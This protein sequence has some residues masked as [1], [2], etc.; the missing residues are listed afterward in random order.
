M[1]GL[2]TKLRLGAVLLFSFVVLN[3]DGSQDPNANVGN[4]NLTLEDV[5]DAQGNAVDPSLFATIEE[6]NNDVDRATI[7]SDPSAEG[8]TGTFVGTATVT[9]TEDGQPDTVKTLRATG[10]ATLSADPSAGDT[11][12]MVVTIEDP[13]A[14]G[15]DAGG[16]TPSGDGTGDGG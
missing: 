15:G 16:G 11:L 8:Y 2:P 1:S 6:V 10:T 3:A 12:E 13:N 4:V 9:W 14:G 7:T 5:K